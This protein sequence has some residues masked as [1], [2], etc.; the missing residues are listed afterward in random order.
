MTGR[1]AVAPHTC[2]LQVEAGSRNADVR[3]EGQVEI[4][5]CAVQQLGNCG[6]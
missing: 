6:A 5:G 3:L 2:V 4:V 1:R